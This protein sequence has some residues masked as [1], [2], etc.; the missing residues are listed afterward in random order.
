MEKE[1]LLLQRRLIPE[2]KG[3]SSMRLSALLCFTSLSSFPPKS[4]SKKAHTTVTKV[5][6]LTMHVGDRITKS[7]KT[8]HSKRLASPFPPQG[9]GRLGIAGDAFLVSDLRLFSRL[10]EVIAPQAQPQRQILGRQGQ[11]RWKREQK[12][13]LQTSSVQTSS[14]VA[15]RLPMPLSL[16]QVMLLA[17]PTLHSLRYIQSSL[18]FPDLPVSALI[19]SHS[20]DV[21]SPTFQSKPQPARHR[22]IYSLLKE[23]LE[24]QGGIHALQLRTKTPEEIE[25]ENAR[26]ADGGAGS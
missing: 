5:Q 6:P 3:R 1:L 23:E 19:P 14:L 2:Q 12:Y 20:L 22:M 15:P 11:V 7:N 24:R 8:H 18:P 13:R 25:R 26:K 4:T 17:I 10:L 9:Y 21:T 16:P